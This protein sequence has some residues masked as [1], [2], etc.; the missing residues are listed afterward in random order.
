M[1]AME[2][3]NKK[4]ETIV[5][6]L[7]AYEIDAFIVGGRLYRKATRTENTNYH[8]ILFKNCTETLRHKTPH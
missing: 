5:I 8:I 2:S 6:K 4:A 7:I 1:H 3:I